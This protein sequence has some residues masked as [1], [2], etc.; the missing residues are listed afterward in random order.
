MRTIELEEKVVKLEYELDMAMMESRVQSGY[1]SNLR[2]YEGIVNGYILQ[3][4]ERLETVDP[5]CR[6][7]EF[8]VPAMPENSH[9]SEYT[10]SDAETSPEASG[11]ISDVVDGMAPLSMADCRDARG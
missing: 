6:L 10:S 9:Q 3:L 4:K 2:V 7:L 11:L 5:G 1:I 8:R